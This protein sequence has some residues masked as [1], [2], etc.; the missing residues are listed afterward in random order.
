MSSPA[1]WRPLK[2]KELMLA[3]ATVLVVGLSLWL[4]TQHTYLS[5]PSESAIDICRQVALLGIATLGVCVVIIAGG[6]DLS[7]GSMIAFSGSVCA[8]ILVLLEP[9]IM[10]GTA[11][12]LDDGSYPT[13]STGVISAAILGALASGLLV[14]SLHAWL[15]TSIGLPPFIATLAT[16]VGLRSV[17][18]LM[19]ENVTQMQFSSRQTQIYFTDPKFLALKEVWISTAVFALLA[20]GVWVLLSR[21]VV[22]RHL[23]A[24]GGNEQA[25]RLS[26]IRT[27]N[28]KWLA[29]CLSA[30]LAATAGVFTTAQ[31]STAEPQNAGLAEELNAIAAA[32]VGGCSLQGGVGTVPGAALGVIFMRCVLDG[33]AKV[34][35]SGSE[36]YQGLVVGV[37]VVIAVAFSQS[38]QSH[39]ARPLFP[40]LLG[41]AAIAS[42]ACLGGVLGLVVGGTRGHGFSAFA[43]L[44][45]GLTA[46]KLYQWRTLRR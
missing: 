44:A 28:V 5:N 36:I 40:G 19:V 10:N 17:A 12:L 6:I 35:K 14:G 16:L 26:G 37:V 38:R 24:L 29:Y 15:I 43:A 30:M 8:S 33:I 18:R 4:D 39:G 21:T 7:I 3:L 20:L 25:A 2:S 27:N 22:G 41:L 46:T 1:E 42:I 45:I 31:I 9:E 32:V 13:L 23:Y 34:I 11:K